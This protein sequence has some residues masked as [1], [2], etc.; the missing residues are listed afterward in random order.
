MSDRPGKLEHY[1][2]RFGIVAIE[3]GFITPENLVEAFKIQ[4]KEDVDFQTH[5][6]IGEILLDS[7]Y[8]TTME[9]QEV[10]D[11]VFKP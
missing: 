2:K 4:I 11:A 7:G 6:L 8:M 3:K 9:I 5:R 1:E 10:L